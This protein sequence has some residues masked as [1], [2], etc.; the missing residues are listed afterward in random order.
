MNKH[1]YLSNGDTAVFEELYQQY[2]KD[3]GSVDFGWQ[4]FFEGFELATETYDTTGAIPENVQKEFNVI[5]LING[6]RQRGHLFTK[7]NPVRERRKYTPSLDIEN[8]G[9]EE[10]DLDLDF[11][12]GS[13]IG[14]GAAT[15][16][17]IISH[18]QQTYCQSIGVEYRY[19]R[20]PKVV[21]WLRNRMESNK[22][23]PAFSQEEKWHILAKLNEAVAFEQFLHTKFVGQKRFSLEGCETFAPAIDAVVQ[24]GAELGIEEFVVGMAHRGRLNMLTNTFR[25]SYEDI[26]SEFEGNPYDELSFG[27]DV[28]YHLGYS[29]DVKTGM[30]KSVHLSLAANPSHLEAVDPIVEGTARAKIDHKYNGDFNKVCPIL[31]HGDASVAGQGVVYEVVQ[32]SQLNGYKTGG[33][34][35]IVINNQIGFT[36]NYLDG[37][38]STYC[39]D[40][41]KITLSPI[42]HVNADDV[43]SVVLAVRLAMEFRQEFHRDVFIDLLG[44]RKHGH[45]EGDEPKFTQ[46]LLYNAIAKHPNPRDIYRD[47]LIEEGSI[48]EGMVKHMDEEFRNILQE[49]LDFVRKKEDKVV[50][51]KRELG[52]PWKGKRIATAADFEQSPKTAVGKKKLLDLAEKMLHL[53]E[54]KNFFRKVK[55]LFNDR[56][57]MIENNALDW[58]MGELLAYATLLD[59]GYPVR[60]SGQDVQRGTFSHRHA[61]IIAEDTAEIYIPL[62]HLGEKQAP[63]NIYNSLLSEFG[64]VGFEYGYASVSP[65]RLIIWEA[66][67]GDFSNEAQVIIDQFISAAEDKWMRQNG[68]VML[69]PH[70]YEGQGSE[71]SS[72]RLERYLQLCA[73]YNLQIVNCTT[74]ANLFHLLRRQLHRDFCK[75][76]IVFT[77]KSLLRHPKCVSPVVDFTKDGFKEVIDDDAVNVKNV[78]KIVFCSGK[79]YYDLIE[80]REKKK[81]KN[82]AFVRIE[83]LYPLAYTQLENIISK[84]ENAQEWLWVQEEPENMGAWTHMMRHFKHKP[85]RVISRP[86]SATPATGSG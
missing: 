13:E 21:E 58:A 24:K 45:N 57:T 70:G 38:S 26:F 6:Y 16:R 33:T 4:K 47:K 49:K 80:Q 56:K 17:N 27:G 42:F 64:V 66:Q 3:N 81:I 84:Y 52:G 65:E 77:P 55:K 9:L 74:P 43:E 51:V 76:L 75:P 8:F 11:Q 35:H 22:N 50:T 83:Q 78:E 44:Y 30:G 46:P 69:L 20:Q 41:G 48:N 39:T 7:T 31:V 67:F 85:L 59:E 40:V 68:L 86:E 18:L 62:Q 36:T 28:K 12:A 23:T 82:I 15:L 60:I 79:I 34:V 5:N 2:K 73:E 63:F 54:E 10:S 19:I 32:M 25:K 37:R 53:P 72:A 14:I 61:A 29:A 71:H 1:S